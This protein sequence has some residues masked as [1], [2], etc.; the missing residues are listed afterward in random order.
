MSDD[1]AG[2]KKSSSSDAVVGVAPLTDGTLAGIILGGVFILLL[3]LRAFLYARYSRPETGDL[4]RLGKSWW[5]RGTTYS[6][7]NDGKDDKDYDDET[8]QGVEME[9]R[10]GRL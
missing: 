5:K 3:L 7:V 8:L 4:R 2:S 6:R 10:A 9:L 1:G